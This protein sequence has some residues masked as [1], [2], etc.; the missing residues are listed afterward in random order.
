MPTSY[1]LVWV[2]LKQGNYAKAPHSLSSYNSAIVPRMA[3][4]IDLYL[5]VIPLVHISTDTPFMRQGLTEQ[6]LTLFPSKDFATE[7][8]P[9]QVQGYIDLFRSN[10]SSHLVGGRITGY[11]FVRE[12]T[13]EGL[14]IVKVTQNV[15]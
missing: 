12:N 2:C 9:E 6:V 3:R 14:V 4:S 10:A 8:Y 5:A 7:F 1:L 13:E 15:A 11:D